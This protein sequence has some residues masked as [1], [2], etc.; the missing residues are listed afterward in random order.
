MFAQGSSP[1]HIDFTIKPCAWGGF[2]GAWVR[3]RA[4]ALSGE[5][6]V[7]SAKV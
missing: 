4:R 3:V 5:L 1:A 2:S 6:A 7:I